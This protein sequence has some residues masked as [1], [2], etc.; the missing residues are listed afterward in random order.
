VEFPKVPTAGQ[1][2]DGLSEQLT[3]PLENAIER[4]MGRHPAITAFVV[5]VREGCEVRGRRELRRH[6][7]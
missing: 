5:L 1:R 2:A 3:A 7:R 6:Q 4:V